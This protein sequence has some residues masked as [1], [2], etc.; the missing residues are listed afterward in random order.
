MFYIYAY[1]RADHTPYY[2]GKGKDG[3]AFRKGKGEIR[4][5]SPERIVIMESNL[6]EVGAFALERFYIRWYG[7]KDLGTGILRN[8]TDGGEGAS[9]VIR[10][11]L[12]ERNRTNH[13]CKGKK[14]GPMSDERKANISKALKGKSHPHTDE[15][16]KR[17][18]GSGNP[19]FGKSHS[20]ETKQKM[21][22]KRKPYG[23]QSEEHKRNRGIVNSS[24][25]SD[26]NLIL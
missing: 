22:G 2:I 6:T 8:M 19:M 24:C 18:S 23:P 10:K 17:I 13:P 20:E 15:H 26:Y 16:K 5:P 9:G 12:S 1:L 7:R 11:D 14:F 25:N 4:P 21:R 3:R